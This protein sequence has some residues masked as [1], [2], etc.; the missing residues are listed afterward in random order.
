MS[1]NAPSPKLKANIWFDVTPEIMIFSIFL[2]Y[3]QAF[4][5]VF[6]V[7]TFAWD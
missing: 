5:E 7:S 6:F 4:G 3:P 2:K 1:N